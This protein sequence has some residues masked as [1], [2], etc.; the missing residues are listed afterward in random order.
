MAAVAMVHKEVHQRTDQD[1]QVRQG[2]KDMRGVRFGPV[3]YRW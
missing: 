1:E 3:C 2:A